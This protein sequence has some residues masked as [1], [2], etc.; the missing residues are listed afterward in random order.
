LPSGLHSD[1]LQLDSAGRFR[2]VLAP[3]PDNHIDSLVLF[4]T[5]LTCDGGATTSLRYGSSPVSSQPV[6]LPTLNLQY[7]QSLPGLQTGL[8]MCG[9][10]RQPGF[11][12]SLLGVSLIIDSLADSVFGRYAIDQNATAP[13]DEGE[14][15]G[16][17][18]DSLL[19]LRFASE[20]YPPCTGVTLTVPLI[21]H[22][23]FGLATLTAAAEDFC[24]ATAGQLRLFPH[25]HGFPPL[26][27][28]AA[29]R[30]PPSAR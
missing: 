11:G 30:H 10:L 8:E 15:A 17:V 18:T 22:D 3:F 14:F 7:P 26:A 9:A 28:R 23:T 12:G 24:R 27:R 25:H 20:H 5:Q 6:S 19:V 4:A 2:G 1:T 29:S 16:R 21:R 13:S